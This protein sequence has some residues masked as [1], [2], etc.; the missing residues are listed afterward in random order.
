[1]DFLIFEA[2]GTS[3]L[4]VEKK[5]DELLRLQMERGD[6]LV[7]VQGLDST[8][9]ACPLCKQPVQ[10]ETMYPTPG[11]EVTVRKCGCQPITNVGS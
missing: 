10:Y 2:L 11:G 8:G 6:S 7:F 9:Q 5:L 3:L 4:R 1:M